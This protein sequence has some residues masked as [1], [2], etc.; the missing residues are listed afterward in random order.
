MR[1]EGGGRGGKREVLMERD[2]KGKERKRKH[3]PILYDHPPRRLAPQLGVCSAFWT[4]H[5]Q[6]FYP[7]DPQY[8]EKPVGGQDWYAINHEIDIEFPGRPGAAPT[9]ISFERFLANTWV[10]ENDDE[11]EVNYA[12]TGLGDLA[13]VS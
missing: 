3:Q 8:V 10:G 6:E 13:D 5:Y 2:E 1:S 11:Y 12:R 4:F 9:D 7:G